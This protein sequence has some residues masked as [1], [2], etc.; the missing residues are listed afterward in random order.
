ME[1]TFLLIRQKCSKINGAHLRP[2]ALL[3]YSLCHN[4][5]TFRAWSSLFCKHTPS[6]ILMNKNNAIILWAS[7]PLLFQP[8]CLLTLEI[9]PTFLNKLTRMHNINYSVALNFQCIIPFLLNCKSSCRFYHYQWL[10]NI[11]YNWSF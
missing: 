7:L 4:N 9:L 1:N 6:K 5:N 8:L 10:K 2:G 3:Y 11:K